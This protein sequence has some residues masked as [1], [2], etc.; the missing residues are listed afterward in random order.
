MRT[1]AWWV[2]LVAVA[3]HARSIAFG[4]TF[5]DDE[6][7]IV[8][9]HAFLAQPWSFLRAFT[10]PYLGVVDAHHAYYRPLVTA[11]YALDARW[12]GVRPLGYHAT[13]VALHAVAS[14][15]LYS[16]L[17]RLALGP[18]VALAAALV[19]AVHP[20]PA[21]A[22]A[23]LPGRNDSLL[24]VFALTA[25]LFFL[26]DRARPGYGAKV[27]HFAFFAL[28]LFT[29]ETAI[30]LPLVCLA[31]VALVPGTPSS[32]GHLRTLGVYGVGWLAAIAGV[33]A[34]RPVRVQAS[35]GVILHNLPVAAMALGQIVFP[36][37][38]RAL[39]AWEDVPVWPGLV[40]A[41]AIAVATRLVP[42]AR[43]RVVALGAA[44]FGLFLVPSLAV[45]G[46]LF[47]G[48]R[49]YLPACGVILA[50]AE[51][52]RGV[53]MDPKPGGGLQ[54]GYAFHAF[55]GVTVASL[56]MITLG[57]E[58][59]FRDRRTFAR[60]AAAS[61]PHSPLAHL[62]LGQALQISGDDDRALAEYETA[63]ALGP[64]E[65]AHNNIAVIHMANARWPEAERELREELAVDPRYGRAYYNLGIV[66]RR[67]GRQ[68]EACAA[69]ERA[70]E[71][72]PDDPGALREL[73]LDQCGEPQ[74]AAAPVV[75]TTSS[76]SLQRG[77]RPMP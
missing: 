69:E 14:A 49:L 68:D 44:A 38:P 57:Y 32:A 41:C 59:T 33:L 43:P 50:V 65:I 23:W 70:L 67:E 10:R 72:V 25:W 30:V 17:R 13:N 47:L 9:D 8:E 77:S 15:L 42:A 19:F 73:A 7:V 28:A 18:A 53:A 11:S 22:V 37:H 26:I 75:P 31:H 45:P 20:V 2:G 74:P 62:C 27:A 34:S 48:S 24:A 36:F 66:L 40:A 52:A 21:S 76:P 64:A 51:L 29:K 39:A 6:D 56:A 60:E 54:G 3:V 46:T 16:L 1:R 5:L 35:L 12:S 4:Y 63:L 55:A 61:S 71:L 58:G